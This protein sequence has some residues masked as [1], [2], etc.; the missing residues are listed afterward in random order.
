MAMAVIG[1]LRLALTIV[2][3]RSPS[4]VLVLRLALVPLSLVAVLMLQILP[5]VLVLPL[6]LPLVLVLLK[7][8]ALLCQRLLVELWI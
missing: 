5:V 7:G 2:L 6:V 1:P 4:R 3:I 8:Q